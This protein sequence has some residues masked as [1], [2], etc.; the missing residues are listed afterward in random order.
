MLI[1]P[2]PPLPSSAE[3]EQRLEE[4]ERRLDH[5]EHTDDGAQQT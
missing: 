5:P 1:Q 4:L 2:R 3:F